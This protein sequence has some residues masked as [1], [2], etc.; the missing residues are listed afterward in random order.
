MTD[1]TLILNPVPELGG[2]AAVARL[3]GLSS[4]T[5]IG[6]KG[7]V[8]PKHCP[9]LER[10]LLGC[11]SVEEMRPDVRWI[12]VPDADWPHPLGRPCEDHAAPAAAPTEEASHAA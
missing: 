2:P 10:A 7:R 3:L 4:P 5:V 12:R 11:R 6:W 8:P 1:P 9:R